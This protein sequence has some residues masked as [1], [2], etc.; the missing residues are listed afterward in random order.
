M[1]ILEA[2][3]SRKS[4][5]AF[6][7]DPVPLEILT[8]IMENAIKAPSWANTQPWEF[9]VVSG[10][11]LKDIQRGFAEKISD[12]P[13]MEVPRPQKYPEIYSNRMQSLGKKELDTLGIKREDKEGRGWWRLQNFNNYG[14]PCMIY[15]LTERNYHYQAEGVNSWPVYDCG[16]ISE[17]IM[18]LAVNYGLGTIVQ[19]QSVVF[20][21]VIRKILAIPESKLILVGIAIGYPD[22]DNKIAHFRSDKET[23][24]KLVN[25]YGF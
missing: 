3:N 23:L 18:L 8:K 15:L 17:N 20:P 7:S 24:Q 16:L 5:R 21:Q 4:I 25:W 14:A 10:V 11:K 9:A 22:W 19:A 2:I 1:D 13:A 12:V 6:K